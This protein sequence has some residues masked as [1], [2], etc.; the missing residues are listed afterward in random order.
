M[1]HPGAGIP[2]NPGEVLTIGDRARQPP[3]T[4]LAALQVQSAIRT[5]VATMFLKLAEAPSWGPTWQACDAGGTRPWN[6]WLSPVAQQPSTS[7]TP[8]PR[9]ADD[10]FWVATT[11]TGASRIAAM[12]G[13]W[14]QCELVHDRVIVASV[15]ANGAVPRQWEWSEPGRPSALNCVRP[16]PRGKVT[17]PRNYPAASLARSLH[18]L[19]ILMKDVNTCH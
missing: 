5:F 14:L 16:K 6:G 18:Q 10:H 4:V 17:F 15:T 8:T 13:D 1:E 11:S 9:L 12:R 7:F 2:E 3:E 19:E